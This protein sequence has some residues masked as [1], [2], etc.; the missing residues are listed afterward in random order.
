ML[1]V[2]AMNA[3]D[4]SR[5][6][7]TILDNS[8]DGQSLR[9]QA[10]QSMAHQYAVVSIPLPLFSPTRSPFPPHSGTPPSLSRPFA[11]L[12]HLLSF[13][14]LLSYTDREKAGL[15][16]TKWFRSFGTGYLSLQSTQPQTIGYALTDSPV[17]LLSW[18]YE[19]LVQWT[20]EYKWDDDE[21][22]P[23]RSLPF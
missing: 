15:A 11:F 3:E 2:I 12:S 23:D 8:Q 7:Q 9:P 10:H 20:D 19:K 13:I 6:S 17:G 5:Y 21:G 14:P 16:R 22:L 4:A 1:L 18:I